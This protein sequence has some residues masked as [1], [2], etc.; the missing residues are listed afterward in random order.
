MSSTAT[1]LA[2]SHHVSLKSDGSPVT[3]VDIAIETAITARISCQFPRDAILGEELG[4]VPEASHLWIVD[5]IDGTSN[6]VEGIPIYAHLIS[7]QE[8]AHLIFALVSAPLLGKRWWAYRGAGS[9]QGAE[10]IHVSTTAAIIEAR[11][12]YGGLRDYPRYA[13]GFV[14]LIRTCRRAR[15]F[16]NFLPHMLVAEGTYDL[17]SSGAGCKPWDV[18]PLHL[19]VG[20]AGGLL[21]AFDGT[22]FTADGPILASNGRLHQDAL[23]L[24]NGLTP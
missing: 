3:D 10:R 20:E 8:S 15:G 12:S 18:A 1:F 11:I 17:A 23:A 19:I 13:D 16:G 6:F 5:P 14:R 9:Y 21:T 7:Y 4:G 2:R 22:G 24:I